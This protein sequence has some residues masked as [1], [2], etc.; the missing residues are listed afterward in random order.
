MT[1]ADW[2]ER[3]GATTGVTGTYPAKYSFNLSTAKCDND[4]QPD[5]VVY[6]TE[7]AGSGIQASLVAY[8][9]LYTGCPGTDPVPSI[10]WAYNTGTGA[11][12]LSSPS[13][14]RDGTQVAFVQT[15][16]AFG[17]PVSSSLV[18][19]KWA[20]STTETV[21]SPDTLTALPPAL[22]PTC[23]APCMTSFLLANTVLSPAVDSE[24]SAAVDLSNDIAWVGDDSG[25]LHKFS[26]VY[27]GTTLNPPAEITTGFPA[28]LNAVNAPLTAAIPDSLSGN[29]FVGD[30]G[31]LGGFLY[32][33]NS[34]TGLL[35]QQSGKLDSGV[36][37]KQGPVVDSTAQL[38]YVFVSSDGSINCG[39]GPCSGVRALSTNF[40]A[41]D[42]GIEAIVGT[43][44]A[45]PNPLY[46]GAFDSTYFNSI[47]ASGDLYVCG[48]T[49]GTPT[50]YQVAISGGVFGT[51]NTGPEVSNAVNPPCSPVTD[52]FNPNTPGGAT[53]FIFASTGVAGVSAGCHSAG[54]IYNFNVTPWMASTPYL[55]GQEVVDSNFQIQVVTQAGTSGLTPPIWSMTVGGNT[56]DGTV[57]W[58]DQGVTSTITPPAWAPSTAYSQGT[59]I[60]DTNRNIE[61]VTTAGTSD[62]G[63]PLFNVLA[64][65][66]TTD[67]TVIW[68]NLGQIP[69]SSAEESNGTSGIIVDN[70]VGPGTIPGASQIYFF[71]L[72]NQTCGAS[73]FASRCA[74]QASQSA[75]Q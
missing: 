10:Y 71:T 18:L 67:N 62:V 12:I 21:A 48:N 30:S 46:I 27:L 7:L 17:N 35:T 39:G 64:G 58:V 26:P 42:F 69:T 57:Q 56:T 2:S 11:K 3:L 41:G 14:S 49:G 23:I 40:T 33:V 22:Y 63:P 1:R 16:F 54:C 73:I 29:V 36:G 74:I 68:T 72:G 59:K 75:L 5:F 44:S 25:F 34:S 6:S 47:D 8:D 20:P 31:S 24:S 50:L 9:N 28:Q 65:G 70:T 66:T 4:P 60:V 45:T 32:A 37:I 13:F 19:L 43:S 38:V 15:D 52:I 51:V 61:L 53:E 55:I